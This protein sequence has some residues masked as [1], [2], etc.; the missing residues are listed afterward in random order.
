MNKLTQHLEGLIE[1]TKEYKKMAGADIKA[2]NKVVARLEEA[3][4]WSQHMVKNPEPYGPSPAPLDKEA[5]EPLPEANKDHEE[6]MADGDDMPEDFLKQDDKTPEPTRAELEEEVQALL[7]TL[8]LNA[9]DEAKLIKQFTT[10]ISTK[11]ADAESL[12]KLRDYLEEE[13]D[14]KIDAESAKDENLARIQQIIPGSE[15]IE[16]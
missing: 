2:V 4:L 8:Q 7:K 12:K 3:W 10:M 15:P 5:T 16:D 1:K 13:I 9:F 11:K 6:A 14:R